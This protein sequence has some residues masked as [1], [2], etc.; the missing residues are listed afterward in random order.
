MHT[1]RTERA[2]VCAAGRDAVVEPA[3]HQL[4]IGVS[5]GALIIGQTDQPRHRVGV[6]GQQP[7][8]GAGV[9]LGVVLPKPAAGSRLIPRGARGAVSM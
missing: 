9:A 6:A 4:R 3:R 8:R 1:A 7:G 5:A 2:P